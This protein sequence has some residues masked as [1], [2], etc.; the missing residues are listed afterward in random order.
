MSRAGKSTS[1]QNWVGASVIRGRGCEEDGGYRQ[2]ASTTWEE[3]HGEG[4]SDGHA[5]LGSQVRTRIHEGRARCSG[6]RTQEHGSW[7][8]LFG[9]RGC[10]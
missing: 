3:E 4:I 6:G 9:N 7:Y 2:G 8:A 10:W 5:G 1:I